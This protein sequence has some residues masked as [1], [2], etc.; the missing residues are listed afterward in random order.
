M[1]NV[2]G[3]GGGYKTMKRKKIEREISNLG[4]VLIVVRAAVLGV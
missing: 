2:V 4:K 1:G 3:T